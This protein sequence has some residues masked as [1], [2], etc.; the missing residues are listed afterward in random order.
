MFKFFSRAGEAEQIQE[1]QEE[2]D[3]KSRTIEEILELLDQDVNDDSSTGIYVNAH[4]AL[5]QSTVWACC[6]IISEIIATLPVKCQTRQGGRW[7]EAEQHQTIDLIHQPNDWMTKHDLVSFLIMWSELRGN[8]YLFKNQ[9]SSGEVKRLLPLQ[10]DQ[11]DVELSRDWKLSYHAAALQNV[12]QL[13]PKKIFHLRN[14]GSSGYVGL[15]TIGNHRQGVGLALQLEEHAA[16]AYKNGLQSPK[17]IQ[18]DVSSSGPEKIKELKKQLDE[19]RGQRKAG[20]M[21]IIPKGFTLHEGN[22]ISA[23]DAQYIE[24]RKMQKQEIA[25]IFGVPAF[26]I[27]DTEKSTTWGSGLEQL[28]RAFVKFSLDPRLDRLAQTFARELLKDGERR[29]TRYIFDTTEFTLGQFKERM[30]GYRSGIESGVFN[31]NEAREIEGYNPREG[32]DEYR[33]PSNMIVEGEA[34]ANDPDPE[35]VVIDDEDGDDD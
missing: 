26:L 3:A 24:S 8:G 5:R 14:F 11:V 29:S 23:T 31:P 32:G 10:A 34:A 1:L 30:D 33:Q 12:G 21:P 28:S 7:V 2:L 6:R 35:P 15:S 25:A 4:T 9:I 19:Y 13:S 17:W 27:N 16:S 18:S 20:K 22:G